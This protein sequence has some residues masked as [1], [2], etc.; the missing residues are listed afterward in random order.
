MINLMLHKVDVHSPVYNADGIGREEPNYDFD[1]PTR[2]LKCNCQDYDSSRMDKYFQKDIVISDVLFFHKDPLLS[3]DDILV[4][5][6]R[7]LMMKAGPRNLINMDRVWV[8]G[9]DKYTGVEAI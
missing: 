4:F 7:K 5:R 2:T 9:A 1:T 8:C 6:G 3:P